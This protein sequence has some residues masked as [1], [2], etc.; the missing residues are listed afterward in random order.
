MNSNIL[1][2]IRF[3]AMTAEE[4]S[5]IVAQTSGHSMASA[6]FASDAQLLSDVMLSENTLLTRLEQ[7]AVFMNL[8]IPTITSVPKGNHN[9]KQITKECR[10]KRKN[11]HRLH[12]PFVD[13]GLSGDTNPRAAPPEYFVARRY[14]PIGYSSGGNFALNSTSKTLRTVTSKFQ[15]LNRDLFLIGAS[16]PVRLDAR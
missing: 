3:L 9:P 14:K 16:I 8:S 6:D 7:V 10:F 5:R 2:Q 1:K 11:T 13:L 4:F 12:I 15:L